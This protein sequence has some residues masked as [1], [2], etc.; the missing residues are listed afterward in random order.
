MGTQV[1]FVMHPADEGEFEQLL[2]MDE[3]IRFIAGPR[4]KTKSP[5][6]SR[7]LADIDDSYRIIWSTSDIAKLKAE[8]IP[9]QPVSPHGRCTVHERSCG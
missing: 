8:Y 5:E 7:S 4:W 2:L 3:S 6:T 9:N 1:R